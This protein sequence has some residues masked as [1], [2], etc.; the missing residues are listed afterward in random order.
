MPLIH[1]MRS[2]EPLRY[3]FE[4]HCISAVKSCSEHAKV[5]DTTACVGVSHRDTEF[6]TLASHW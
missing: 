6:C 1:R 3:M 2:G 4:L 5:A